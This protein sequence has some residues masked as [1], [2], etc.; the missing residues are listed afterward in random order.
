MILVLR[1]AP[2]AACMILR[3][4]GPMLL[5]Y[6]VIVQKPL[7]RKSRHTMKAANRLLLA[8]HFVR[9]RWRWNRLRGA[10]LERYKEEYL[11]HLSPLGWEYINLTGDFQWNMNARYQLDS[12]G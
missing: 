1:V 5:S 11:E 3:E 9:A 12:A 4:P 2:F 8:T 6:L 10:A 7:R